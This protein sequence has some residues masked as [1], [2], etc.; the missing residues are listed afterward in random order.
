MTEIN[1]DICTVCSLD[2][3]SENGLK[4]MWTDQVAHGVEIMNYKIVEQATKL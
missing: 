2:F 4:F 3:S 1:G